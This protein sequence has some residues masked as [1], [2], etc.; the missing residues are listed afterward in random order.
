MHRC[1]P[2]NAVSVTSWWQLCWLHQDRLPTRKERTDWVQGS[3]PPHPLFPFPWE[4]GVGSCI[5]GRSLKPWGGHK[6]VTESAQDNPFER[7]PGHK[8]DTHLSHLSK[9]L[10]WPLRPA[11]LGTPAEPRSHR[12][13]ILPA[14]SAATRHRRPRPRARGTL[15]YLFKEKSVPSPRQEKLPSSTQAPSFS[16]EVFATAQ[17]ERSQSEETQTHAAPH[18]RTLTG[19]GPRRPPE[20]R[21]AAASLPGWGGGGAG[22][23]PQPRSPPARA[24]R[25]L[26][27]FFCHQLLFL[28]HQPLTLSPGEGD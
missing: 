4:G 20:A 28:L 3:G 16:T 15:E 11:H 24:A 7:P 19:H 2:G 10:P 23:G 1:P 6:L 17:G 18:T 21:T 13:P 25:H 12:W 26:S 9:L 22:A 27:A 14:C 5:R 8:E